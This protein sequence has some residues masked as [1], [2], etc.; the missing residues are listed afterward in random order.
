M[1]KGFDP[2]T[3]KFACAFALLCGLATAPPVDAADATDCPALSSDIVTDRPNVT[4][5][6]LAVPY[7][8]LQVENGLTW[9]ARNHSNLL[10]GSET[11]LR[12]GVAR[13]S[14]VALDVPNF[15]Y[16]A[17]GRAPSGFS[18]LGLSIKRQF[19]PIPAGFTLSATAGLIFPTGA[20][21]ISGPGYS[22][23]LQFPWAKDLDG[24]WSVSGMFTLAWF[25]DQP[26]Q[27]PTFAPS[28]A[29]GRQVTSACDATFEYAGTYDHQ[30]PRQLLDTG[31]V[32]RISDRQQIDFQAGFGLNRSSLD[33]FFGL[34]Y[35]IRIDN[36][37]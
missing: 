32:Y 27:N 18:N 10:D 1:S 8:S 31:A 7:G 33:H 3:L 15:F 11:R 34:G 30:R 17:S 22:P 19:A 6:S 36:L 23:Y 14:E 37:L 4:N 28:F 24:G 16:S 29:I 35:S 25:T 13:C 5:S 2:T 12:L 9:T 21:R 20:N 26:L